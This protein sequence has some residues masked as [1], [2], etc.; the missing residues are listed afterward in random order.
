MNLDR[1]HDYLMA[2]SRLV[3]A[4][5]ANAETDPDRLKFSILADIYAVLAAAANEAQIPQGVAWVGSER[6]IRGTVGDPVHPQPG[7]ERC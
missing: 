4:R 5:A 3:A 2:Q 1:V 7:D 6:L